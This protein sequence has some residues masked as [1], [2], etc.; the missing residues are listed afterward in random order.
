MKVRRECDGR[1]KGREKREKKEVK[2]TKSGVGSNCQLKMES[3]QSV[4]SVPSPYP[5]TS[6]A[7]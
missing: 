2:N 7:E 4:G 5:S 1:G 6:S 3:I